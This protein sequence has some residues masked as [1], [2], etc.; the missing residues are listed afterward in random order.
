MQR[1]QTRESLMSSAKTSAVFRFKTPNYSLYTKGIHKQIRV[2]KWTGQ[3]VATAFKTAFGNAPHTGKRPPVVVGAIPFSAQHP[4][5]L[6][7][8]KHV[9]W[10]DGISKGPGRNPDES[11]NTIRRI[12]GE[13]SPAYRAAVAKALRRI[14]IGAVDKVVL[15]RRLRVSADSAFDTDEIFNRLCVLN[16]SAFVYQL[17]LP[18]AQNQTSSVLLGASPELVLNST[19]GTVQ[20]APLAGSIPRVSS[21]EL[22]QKRG[23]NLLQSQKDLHEH[24]VVVRAVGD[25]FRRHCTDAMVPAHPE[26][27]K[28]PVIWHLGSKISGLLRE[29]VHPVQLAYALHPTPAVSGWPQKAAQRAIAELEDFERGFYAGLIGWMDAEGNGEWALT[30]RCGLISGNTAQVFAGA[31]IVENSD[32]EAEHTETATKLRTFL[33]AL[34]RVEAPVHA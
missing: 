18:Q 27:V 24:A 2:A 1:D 12:D 23:Q 15:A 19:N 6:Y 22:D 16:Q 9:E 3:E 7:I 30:L 29:G 17:D 14:S 20:S 11:T 13:D 32:P 4:A 28:T 8:P 33:N 31:G 34:G 25:Q 21:T 5:H 10:G 26:L